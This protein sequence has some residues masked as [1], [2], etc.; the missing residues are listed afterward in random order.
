M[1]IT[2]LG[3]LTADRRMLAAAKKEDGSFDFSRSLQFV[4]DTIKG[5]D[6]VV[7]N[8]ETVFGGARLGYN[9][10]PIAYNSPDELLDAF[11]AMG[12]TVMTTAN[13]HSL[14]QGKKGLLRTLDLIEEAG[15]THTGTFRT[16]AEPRFLVQ[17]VGGI[18]IG[19]VA[20]ADAVNRT[21]AGT[22]Q[23]DDA[24]ALVN[25]FRPYGKRSFK[26]N[27]IAGL[28]TFLPIKEARANK[29]KKRSAAGIKTVK[30]RVDDKPL[31][32]DDMAELVKVIDCLDEARK[33]CDFLVACI[34]TGGQF[35]GEPGLHS[36][37]IYEL[38][39]PHADAIM[40]NHAHVA[41]RIE[42]YGGEGVLAYALGGFNMSV[43]AE[44]V[45]ADDHPE[46]SIGVHLYVE[47]DAEDRVRLE[48]A[49]FTLYYIEEDEA[50]YLTVYPVNAEGG[51]GDNE[52]MRTVFRRIAG[53]DFP[54]FME[55]YPVAGLSGSN[56]SR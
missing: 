10:W 12:V 18:R 14:D 13:N 47:K 38:L 32:P 23:A 3:D 20:Y 11:R 45:T 4:P 55:E 1:K 15:M 7:G 40:G 28:S 53:Y 24:M 27:L 16:T 49:T 31:T 29:S 22:Q 39:K 43:G 8:L 17:D 25:H 36:Q 35:N 54:G 34:H 37:S 9:P 52:A 41:Q 19:L 48:K 51:K 46:F 56:R 2:F 42:I 30:P 33:S 6:A 50:G 26:E 44:Y 21:A 5:S